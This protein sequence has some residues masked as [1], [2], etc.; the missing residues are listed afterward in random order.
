MQ[1]GLSIV[2]KIS[3]LAS[4][5]I[6]SG[7]ATAN[8]AV[9]GA[10]TVD[11]R[12]SSA[13]RYQQARAWLGIRSYHKLATQSL[14]VQGALVTRS[15]LSGTGST[16]AAFATGYEPAAVSVTA[17]AAGVVYTNILWAVPLAGASRYIG[18]KVTPTPSTTATGMRW[19]TSGG[20]ALTEANQLV[21][22]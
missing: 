9:T 17:T 13:I 3:L 7:A 20:F 2:P 19:V 16:W 6:D 14:S 1:Q 4:A 22:T 8:A 21:A 10:G 11:L 5:E 12:P 18:V 15:T